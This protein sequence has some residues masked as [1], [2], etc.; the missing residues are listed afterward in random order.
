MR[1]AAVRIASGDGA[2]PFSFLDSR[3][4]FQG[5]ANPATAGATGK[6]LFTT[7]GANLNATYSIILALTKGI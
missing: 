6:I 1:F 3:A 5:I 7:L 2:G 4:G